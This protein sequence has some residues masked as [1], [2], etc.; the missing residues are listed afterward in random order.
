M[1]DRSKISLWT[2]AK[3]LVGKD[4]TRISLPVFVCEPLSFLQRITEH[5]QYCWML[6]KVF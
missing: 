3:H 2:I 6:S 1:F 5:N 4:L